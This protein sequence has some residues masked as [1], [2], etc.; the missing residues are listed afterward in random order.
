MNPGRILPYLWYPACLGAAI[1]GFAGMLAWGQ[2]PALAAYLPTIAIGLI[3]VLLEFRFPE[4]L[5]WR[6][7][8]ADVKADAAFIRGGS[9]TPKL[10]SAWLGERLGNGKSLHP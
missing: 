3:I 7:R 2:P 6:P 9:D 10:A 1:A 5:E 8:W 4:R